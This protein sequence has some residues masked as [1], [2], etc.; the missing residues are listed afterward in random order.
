MTRKI[1]NVLFVVYL[2]F[3]QTAQGADIVYDLPTPIQSIDARL[4]YLE[5]PNTKT[6]DFSTYELVFD[7]AGKVFIAALIRAA[8]RGVIVRG[9]I[10]NKITDADPMLVNYLREFGIEL[11]FHNP[12]K[13]AASDLLHPI[14]SF[15]KFNRRLHDKMFIV[16][17]SILLL[18]DKNYANKYFPQLK[19]IDPNAGYVKGRELVMIGDGVS[20]YVKYFQDMWDKYEGLKTEDDFAKLNEP[21]PETFKLKIE[22]QLRTSFLWLAK[23]VTRLSNWRKNQFSYESA[24][25]VTGVPGSGAS[26]LDDIFL[27]IAHA[28]PGTK[29]LIENGY[30]VLFPQLKEAIREAIKNNVEVVINLNLKS[31]LWVIQKALDVDLEEII[32]L[33]AKVYLNRHRPTHAK[34]IL[35]ENAHGEKEVV[36]TSANFDPRSYN[37]NTESG[38]SIKSASLN[39]FYWKEFNDR[40]AGKAFYQKASMCQSFYSNSLFP[41]KASKSSKLIVK[42]MRSQL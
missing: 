39:E 14:K 35:V 29:V 22:R 36:V 24:N 7:E 40:K 11:N 15:Q 19:N 13:I 31:E 28:K 38:F 10:D 34:I 37:I 12:I 26:T 25:L 42:A 2:F 21:V 20:S 3:L 23:R 32:E 9:I 8:E 6:V 41:G 30:L 27:K 16:N 5:D 18:G 17:S 1:L 4:S 33:G